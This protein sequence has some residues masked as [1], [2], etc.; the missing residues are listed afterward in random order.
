MRWVDIP[1]EESDNKLVRQ[2][3]IWPQ[4]C[5]CCGQDQVSE[6][7]AFGTRV[8][9]SNSI[10]SGA[11]KYYPVEFIAPYCTV[12]KQHASTNEKTYYIYIVGFFLWAAFGYL[13]FINGL[14]NE[15]LGILIFLFSALLIGGGCYLLSKSIINIFSKSRMKP[16]CSNHNYAIS[17]SAYGLPKIRIQFNRDEY[18]TEFA[19]MNNLV[20][21]MPVEET[22]GS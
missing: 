19:R 4:Q 9:T 20:E 1:Y 10:K 18:A 22:R 15:T 8:V 11:D 3:V 17:A 12:C 21:L 14:G 16:T 13:L 7:Y 5:P 6:Y 2:N